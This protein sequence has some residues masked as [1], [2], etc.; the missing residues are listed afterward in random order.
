MWNSHMMSDVWWD[1]ENSLYLQIWY[2][3]GSVKFFTFQHLKKFTV[4]ATQT[5]HHVSEETSHDS[6]NPKGG[7][8]QTLETGTKF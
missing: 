2:S 6:K 1:R 3:I 8:R 4:F 5:L 7:D